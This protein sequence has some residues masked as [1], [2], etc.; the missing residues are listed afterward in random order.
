MAKSS[1]AYV[2]IIVSSNIRSAMSDFAKAHPKLAAFGRAA[3]T[4]GILAAAGMA[5]AAAAIGVLIVQILRA[6]DTY[7]DWLQKLDDFQDVTDL[8]AKTTSLLAAQFRLADVDIASAQRSIGIFTRRLGEAR[9]GMT[10]PTEA[11]ERLGVA[12]NEVDGTIRPLEDVLLDVR[13]RL[14]EMEDPAQ[15]AAIAA[16]LFGRSWEG[17]AD[18]IDKSNKE[19]A[20]YTEWAKE[21]G[22]IM[23][24]RSMKAFRQYRENQRKLAFAWDAIK[25]NAY[26]A[27][28]PLINKMMPRIIDLIARAT[29]WM[30][31]F[32][33]KAEK[34]GLEKAFEDMAPWVLSVRD[35]LLKAWDYAKKLGSYIVAHKDDIVSALQAIAD[36]ARG[37]AAALKAAKDAYTWLT[38]NADNDKPWHA[39]WTA[40]FTDKYAEG[41]ITTRPVIAGEAGPEAVVPLTKPNRAAEVLA[42]A[43]LL[44]GGG[45]PTFQDCTFIGSAPED[46]LRKL[47]RANSRRATRLARGVA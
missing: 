22:M 6:K 43:G 14:S 27:L 24:E 29:G 16:K 10:A 18:W 4:A 21:L 41:G 44:G 31:R 28:V 38:A 3:K 1:N 5:M 17:M 30:K 36:V 13:G 32:R 37:I 19:I 23:G 47:N 9:Q 15:R 8:S 2:K 20:K 42:K 26:A 25:I 11:F 46:W 34:K 33:E 7:E 39:M 45:G 12:I 40:P 35:A